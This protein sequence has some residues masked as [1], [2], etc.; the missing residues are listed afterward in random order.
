M[1]WRPNLLNCAYVAGSQALSS[2][3]FAFV[4]LFNNDAAGRYIAVLDVGTPD[5]NTGIAGFQVQN[6]QVGANPVTPSPLVANQGTP[7]GVLTVGHAAALPTLGLLHG[8]GNLQ[9][10][11]YHDYPIIVLPAG[12]SITLWR[13]AVSTSITAGFLYEML[14]AEDLAGLEQ[15][16]QLVIPKVLKLSIETE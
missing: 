5:V 1:K 9:A 12:W 4:C 14:L 8:V 7:I 3:N 16:P 10:S 2:G 11:W 6:Q 15:S 13:F